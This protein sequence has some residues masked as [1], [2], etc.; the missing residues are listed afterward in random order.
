TLSDDGIHT[1]SGRGGRAEEEV[2][3]RGSI[4]QRPRSLLLK[5]ADPC[6]GLG[7]YE[8]T[9][10]QIIKI[11]NR[12]LDSGG[13]REGRPAGYRRRDRVIRAAA[14]LIS[15]PSAGAVAVGHKRY[16]SRPVS[17][18]QADLH[19]VACREHSR[20]IEDTGPVEPDVRKLED[21]LSQR[22]A[23]GNGHGG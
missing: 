19:V 4:T 6:A 13:T 21:P 15:R 23:A 12:W 18:S 1:G 5:P 3:R 7:A 11:Q 8:K 20:E 10:I 9:S 17:R 22:D 2:P 16:S 14:G